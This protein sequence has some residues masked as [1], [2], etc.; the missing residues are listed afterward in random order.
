MKL[1]HFG[2]VAVA[3]LLGLAS[4]APAFASGI[5]INSEPPSTSPGTAPATVQTTGGQT[6]PAS[7]CIPMDTGNTQ[8]INPA[9]MCVSPN[10]LTGFVGATAFTQLKY[11]T[12][13]VGSV[14]YGSLG[15]NT[16]PVSG[17]IYYAQLNLPVGIT[18]SKIGCM[19]GGTA[20]TDKLIYALY[21]SAGTLVANT[22][23]SGVTATGTDQFQE[24]ALA[25]N[26][27]A[28]PGL[29]FVAWQ[30][31]GTTTRFRTAATATYV[32]QITGSQTGTFATLP[33]ITSVATTFTADVGPFC[34]VSS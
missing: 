24:I 28:V 15:T 5:W 1:R 33:S 8:G 32:T 4:L 21:N 10:Q 26:Y 29:Y 34:Y 12:F 25:T 3:A 22:S 19:N 2:A 13:P 31:N 20:A 23:L 17:T 18:I 30:D 16:T 14:A 11:L 7:G 6:I 9:T 27:A